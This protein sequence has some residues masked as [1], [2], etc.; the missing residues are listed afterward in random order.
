MDAPS[1]EAFKAGCGSEQPGLV[2]GDPA[3]RRGLK[4]DDHYDPFQPRPFYDP[5][6][7]IYLKRVIPT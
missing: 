6:I 5:V 4:L 7:K 3:H 2:A 1:L